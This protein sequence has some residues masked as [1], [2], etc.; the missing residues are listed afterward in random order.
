MFCTSHVSVRLVSRAAAS[1]AQLVS[2]KTSD[3]DVRRLKS[4]ICFK[5][6]EDVKSKLRL[7]TGAKVIF[8]SSDK[9]TQAQ[10]GSDATN[11][12]TN[13]TLHWLKLFLPVWKHK[14]EHKRNVWLFLKRLRW[15]HG[16]CDV[17]APSRLSC[18]LFGPNVSNSL[19]DCW[20]WFI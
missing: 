3:P 14:V 4:F 10:R 2:L 6:R 11:R 7:Q 19:Y 16:S 9:Q 13:A 12:R 5:C 8:D 18:S 20:M 17:S 15:K 1:S